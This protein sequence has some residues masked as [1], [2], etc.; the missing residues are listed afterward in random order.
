M[1]MASARLLIHIIVFLSPF[2]LK[3]QLAGRLNRNFGKWPLN[4]GW[5]L[6]KGP[7]VV[8]DTL[9][10]TMAAGIVVVSESSNKLPEP[11]LDGPATSEHMSTLL[12]FKFPA[13]GK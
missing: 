3:G 6:N 9:K 11:L 2:C 7:T 1:F 12:P 10:Y 8:V 5:P 4:R 13:S